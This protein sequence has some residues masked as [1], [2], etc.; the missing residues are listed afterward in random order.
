M[1]P[2]DV[3]IGK[4]SERAKGFV[5]LSKQWLVERAIA[6]LN[7]GRRQANDWECLNRKGLA[8]LRLASICLMLL[9]LCIH[10]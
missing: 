7:R 10:E 4:R 2:I 9:K 3:D 5:V 1:A 6:W 8:L